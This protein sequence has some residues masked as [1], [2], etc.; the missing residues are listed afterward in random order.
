MVT[1]TCFPGNDIK[2]FSSK[3]TTGADCCTACQANA[4]CQGWTHNKN[5][6]YLKHTLGDSSNRSPDCISGN[7][8]QTPIPSPAPAPSTTKCP[9]GWCLYDIATDPLEVHEVSAANPD[10]V[11]R[12]RQEMSDVLTT[13][14][15]YRIDDTCPP[16]KWVNDSH[17]GK[18]WGPWCG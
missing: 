16:H 4:K 9:S 10:V 3:T 15:E 11:K 5:V 18:V 1:G 6:C 17:V 7:D 14:T 8:G 2:S 13:Y 12:M